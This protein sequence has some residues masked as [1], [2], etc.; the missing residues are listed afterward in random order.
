[1]ATYNGEKFLKDQIESILNQSYSNWMLL[2]H[3]DG[4]EDETLFFIRHYCNKY[5]DKIILIEDN[6][7]HGCP[8]KN[9]AH[10]FNIAKLKFDFDY[11]MF[12]DQD[13]IWLED[14]IEITLRNMLKIEKHYQ[15][16]PIIVHT[17]LKIVDSYLNI[18]SDSFW[19]YQR[20]NPCNNSISCL[21]LENTVT[22]CTMMI[23][24]FLY[25]RI[26]YFPDEAIMHDWWTALICVSFKGHIIPIEKP[27]VLYRQH[28][29]NDTGAIDYSAS[30]FLKRLMRNPIKSMDNA[31]KM[32]I[33]VRM[34]AKALIKYVKEYANYTDINTLELISSLEN[35]I[36]NQ[37]QRKI[38]YLKN[39]CL[40]GSFIKKM[41]KFL[42]Y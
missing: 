38:F 7:K 23:N 5:P 21:L 30:A 34:Q 14:K 29:K 41:K 4:S 8:K 20:I 6:I 16:T 39:K 26:F 27:T 25:E 19:K 28:E 13:D 22:G 33:K 2:I 12:S 15:N 24:K 42:F 1:M 31:I 36:D 10:I 9:F 35:Q 37:L 40:C 18:I 17:D 3:D 11:I 32:G